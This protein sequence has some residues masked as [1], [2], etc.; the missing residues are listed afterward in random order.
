MIYDKAQ[1]AAAAEPAEAS[2]DGD[3]VEAEIVDEGASSPGDGSSPGDE[4]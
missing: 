3:V 2:G 4:T 1:S